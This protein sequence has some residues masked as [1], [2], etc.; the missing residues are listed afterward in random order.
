MAK[1]YEALRR[2]EEERKQVATG[3]EMRIPAVEWDAT[4]QTA[5]KRQGEWFLARWLVFTSEKIP[6]APEDLDGVAN[7]EPP[8]ELMSQAL[9]ITM[10]V[11]GHEYGDVGR[12]MAAGAS[13][14]VPRI[15]MTDSAREADRSLARHVDELRRTA[16]K[17]GRADDPL[18][19]RTH[20]QADP[21]GRGAAES[22]E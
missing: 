14:R 2:A 8:A 3:T 16:A 5:P 17:L 9:Q 22:R 4:P 15:D 12:L 7:G 13:P 19:A 6:A 10:G 1:I 20:E 21:A 11:E 18:L